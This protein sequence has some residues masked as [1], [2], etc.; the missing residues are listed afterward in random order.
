MTKR[1]QL[2]VTP[3]TCSLQ[4]DRKILGAS[5]AEK[6][7]TKTAKTTQQQQPRQQ[8]ITL[9]GISAYKTFL[10]VGLQGL[11]ELLSR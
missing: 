6:I 8:Q 11:Q 7:F 10:S 2:S 4:N 5:I 3:L 1:L 9:T